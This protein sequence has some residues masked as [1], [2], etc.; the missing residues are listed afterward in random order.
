[1][2]AA[3]VGRYLLIQRWR[4]LPPASVLFGA[5]VLLVVLITA[6]GADFFA[7]FTATAQN[8][9]DRLQAPDLTG[10]VLGTDNLGRD[11]LSRVIYGGRVSIVVGVSAATL[12]GSLGVVLGLMAG[13]LGGWWDAVLSRVADVQQAIPFL[14]LAIAVAVILGPSLLNV[15]LVLA[16]TTWVNY[17]RVVR[18][19]VLS[20]RESLL[21]DAARVIGAPR[22]R[23]VLRH[24]LPNVSASIIVIGSVMVANMIIF[25]ASL[26]FLGLGVPPPTPTWGRMVFEGVQYVDSAWW[27]SFFPGVAIVLTVLAINLIGDWL[28]DVL[29]PRL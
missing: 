19:E 29:D 17:F 1:M 13:F 15:V 26:S 20:V 8:L 14:I 12:A 25:E 23:I 16:V 3:P 22:H 27:V 21:V 24:V 4:R 9:R 28:R 18:A 7:P 10:H 2:P 5:A 6:I 11:I